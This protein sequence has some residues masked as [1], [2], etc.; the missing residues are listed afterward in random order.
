MV[1]GGSELGCA[2]R[3]SLYVTAN[4]VGKARPLPAPPLLFRNRLRPTSAS[5]HAYATTAL[6][7]LL[8]LDAP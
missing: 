7:E 2:A 6:G 5:T 4:A 8:R 1:D 3:R